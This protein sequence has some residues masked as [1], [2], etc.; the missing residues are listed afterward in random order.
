MLYLLSTDSV[1]CSLD[2]NVHFPKIPTVHETPGVI[3]HLPNRFSD[4]QTKLNKSNK[5]Q[6]N[7][8]VN[9]AFAIEKK[10]VSFVQVIKCLNEQLSV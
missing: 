3:H 10:M 1:C 7:K 4:I 9:K 5:K 2:D 6:T 8:N